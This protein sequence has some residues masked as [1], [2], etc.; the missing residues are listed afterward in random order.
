MNIDKIRFGNKHKIDFLKNSLILYIERKIARNFS[1]KSII[2][3]F[4]RFQKER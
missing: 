1:A 3:N 2:Y 4:L